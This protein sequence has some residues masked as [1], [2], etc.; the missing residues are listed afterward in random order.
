MNLYVLDNSVV[1]KPFLGQDSDHKVKKLFLKKEKFEISVLV[2]GIFCYE[3]FNILNRE[4]D[5]KAAMQAYQAFLARQVSVVPLEADII[6]MA[7]KLMGKYPKISFYDAAYHALAKVYK[8][9]LI[10]ADER[11]YQMT[12]KEKHV[13]LL[14]QLKV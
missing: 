2:P 6:Q 1:L 8:A 14:K 13:K 4:L 10:T 9:D 3:F 11:Y 12:K 7:N 5:A